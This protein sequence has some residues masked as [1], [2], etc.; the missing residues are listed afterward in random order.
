[1]HPWYPVAE[2]RGGWGGEVMGD[3]SPP[4]FDKGDKGRDDLCN[5]L[6]NIVKSYQYFAFPVTNIQSKSTDFA[7]KTADL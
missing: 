4:M 2:I 5:H 7:L 1:M 6:P 3:I